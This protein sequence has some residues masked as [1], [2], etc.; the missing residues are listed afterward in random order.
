MRGMA[1]AHMRFVDGSYAMGHTHNLIEPS[2]SLGST[3]WELK[4]KE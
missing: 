4:L 3:P 2:L 1:D